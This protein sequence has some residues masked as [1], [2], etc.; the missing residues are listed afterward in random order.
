MPRQTRLDASGMLNHVMKGNDQITD[1]PKDLF[2]LIEK[3]LCPVFVVRVIAEV[4]S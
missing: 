4:A 2:R 1:N 3:S